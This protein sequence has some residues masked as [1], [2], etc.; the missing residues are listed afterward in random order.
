M[1]LIN[2]KNVGT[3]RQSDVEDEHCDFEHKYQADVASPACHLNLGA[4]YPIPM[5]ISFSLKSPLTIDGALKKIP[6]DRIFIYLSS[7]SFDSGDKVAR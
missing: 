3:H 6:S 7:Y 2:L 5:T 4:E 1:V